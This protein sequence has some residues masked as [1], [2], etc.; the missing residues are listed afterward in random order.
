[1]PFKAL[2]FDLDGTLLDTLEDLADAANRVL[3]RAGLP[4]H[5]RAVYRRFIGDGSRML[6][7]RA[8]PGDH[9]DPSTV[10][11]FLARF[12]A[13]YGGHWKSATHP[14]PGIRDLLGELKAHGIPHA[15][16]T[17]KPQAFADIC[18]RHFFPEAAFR[19][20]LGQQADRPLK[21]DPMPALEAAAQIGVRP[22]EC[23]LLGDS[24][25]DMQTARAAG[26]LPLGAAWGFRPVGELMAAG[27]AGIVHTPM[28][29]LAWFDRSLTA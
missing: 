22:P 12:K 10:D 1:M 21:P 7:T 9:R 23:L 4:T 16:V 14:Y 5:E 19:A 13:D 26:M 29:A 11:R 27:A 6:I 28:E 2:L 25:V 3:H 8:L 24:G 17:N 18:I 20:I 15:V